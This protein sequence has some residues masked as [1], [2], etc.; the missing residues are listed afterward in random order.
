MVLL[1]VVVLVV[2]VVLLLLQR[3]VPA[4]SGKVP[5]KSQLS[6]SCEYGLK[7]LNQLVNNR[8][9]MTI[10]IRTCEECG[11][12]NEKDKISLAALLTVAVFDNMEY[13]TD[14][15]KALLT[16]RIKT[17]SAPTTPSPSIPSPTPSSSSS[18]NNSRNILDLL[19]SN[20]FAILMHSYV[21]QQASQVLHE[22]FE[23]LSQHI[24][25]GPVDAITGQSKWSLCL[26]DVL[27]VKLEYKTITLK[28]CNT[29]DTMKL[30][31]QHDCNNINKNN[32]SFKNSNL[33]NDDDDDDD[34][35]DNETYSSSTNQNNNITADYNNYNTTTFN[36][37]NNNKTSFHRNNYVKIKVLDCDTI[38]Q[39]KHKLIQVLYK[40]VPYSKRPDPENYD[41]VWRLNRSGTVKVL[42][43]SDNSNKKDGTSYRLNT[44]EHYKVDDGAF[45]SLVSRQQETDQTKHQQQHQQQGKHLQGHNHYQ[46]QQQQQRHIDLIQSSRN[47][48]YKLNLKPPSTSNYFTYY[49]P[50]NHSGYDYRHGAD[51]DSYNYFSDNN[52]NKNNNNNNHKNK[53]NNNNDDDNMNDINSQSKSVVQYNGAHKRTYWNTYVAKN[54]SAS[55]Y[56]QSLHESSSSHVAAPYLLTI[57]CNR[58][59]KQKYHHLVKPS[60]SSSSSSSRSN[61][62]IH[63]INL[64]RFVASKDPLNQPI[65]NL[66]KCIFNITSISH[67]LPIK[68]LFEFIDSHLAPT[69]RDLIQ[70]WKV[71]CY[72]LL[73]WCDVISHVDNILDL[74][75][76]T[77]IHPSLDTIAQ[78]LIECCA[79]SNSNVSNFS[80]PGGSSTAV[81]SSGSSSNY[82]GNLF[83][84]KNKDGRSRTHFKNV[85][86]KEISKFQL[87]TKRFYEYVESMDGVCEAEMNLIFNQETKTFQSDFSRNDA[88]LQLYSFMKCSHNEIYKLTCVNSPVEIKLLRN[89]ESD[90]PA[91]TYGLPIR[92]NQLQVTMA[93]EISC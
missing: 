70:A 29:K 46:Q 65:S 24:H 76:S 39:V 51:D 43:D 80:V 69:N 52:N 67:L 31:S 15:I 3:M 4:M 61:P 54:K 62:P 74:P 41:L 1:V 86:N 49:S 89:L 7:L 79:S 36:S 83:G 26:Q 82:G 9:F 33:N 19:L 23:S 44:L 55:P 35:D 92:M 93:S 42:Q 90:I 50:P 32:S 37:S 6:S 18:A 66:F 64:S 11:K 21:K 68:Y 2:V 72:P 20:W 45:V 88:L 91:R 47:D 16:E 73:F 34:D 25:R 8:I 17:S 84:L 75:S 5:R 13:Y 60:T 12:F 87:P 81:G 48:Y 56:S 22:L 28:I 10:F 85:F 27:K 58:H 59:C 57:N 38:S 78:L 14:I 53:N 40:N 63:H 30:N 77:P 71:H